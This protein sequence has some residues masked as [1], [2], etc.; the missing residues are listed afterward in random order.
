MYVYIY[1]YICMYNYIKQC[2]S[3]VERISLLKAQCPRLHGSRDQLDRRRCPGAR[4]DADLG[5]GGRSRQVPVEGHGAF[6][7]IYIYTYIHIYIYTYIHIYMYI[8]IYIY[9]YSG[10][11][12]CVSVP[13]FAGVL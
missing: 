7:H 4:C 3:I 11:V 2:V 8:Y 1:I 10:Y 12:L 6:G 9:I 5:I 13:H